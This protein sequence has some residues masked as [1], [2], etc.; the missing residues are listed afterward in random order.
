L[1]KYV[2]TNKKNNGDNGRRRHA[3]SALTK[4]GDVDNL[5][6]EEEVKKSEFEKRKNQRAIEF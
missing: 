4:G 5:S 6:D 1:E 2:T 3:K